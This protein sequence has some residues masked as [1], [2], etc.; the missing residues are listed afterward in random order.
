MHPY[1]SQF[2]DVFGSTS[3][4]F[5]F[6]K[7]RVALYALLKVLRLEESGNSE[8]ILPGYTCVVVP[9]A[10]RYA[11]ARPVYADITPGEYNLDPASVERR[12][13]NHTRVL[14]IQ[15]TYGIPADVGALKAIAAKHQLF[16]I[17]DCAHVLLGSR[18]QGQLLG[19]FG[20]AAFFSSQWSKP[21]TTGLGGMVVT[22]DRGLAEQL[23]AIQATFREPPIRQ[24]VQLQ[25]QYDLFRRCFTPSRYWLCQSS[26]HALSGFGLFVGSSNSEDLEGAIPPD[27]DWRM[28]EFQQQMGITQIKNRVGNSRHRERLMK[29]YSDGL[30][31]C[32]WP[33]DHYLDSSSQSSVLRYPLKVASKD[34]LLRESRRAKIEVGSWFETPLHPLSLA[35]HDRMDYNLGSCP[36]AESTAAETINLPVH[37]GV[38][39]A[40][41]ERILDFVVSAASPAKSVQK[42][43]A[44]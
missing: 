32:G 18:S 33:V 14:I 42:T 3:Y 19:S 10:V 30:R 41:A 20:D 11:K 7:A 24:R 22:K 6:W 36:A 26:L 44:L 39:Q 12:I 31:Q 1:E 8:V 37:E 13:T 38:T 21:Y 9:N 40:E 28:S 2:A 17:E 16:L 25:V 27:I 43:V 35:A 5:S 4:A 15:H 23:K 34:H 29:F